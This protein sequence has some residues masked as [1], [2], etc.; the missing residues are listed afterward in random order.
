LPSELLERRPDVRRAE[1]LLVQANANIGVA[2]AQFFPSLSLSD[3][4]G[5][6]SSQ[7][8]KIFESGN[9]YTYAVGSLSQPIFD[10]GKIRANYREA[11][12]KDQELID[13]SATTPV[14]P[15]TS[16]SLP[17]T[18]PFT[19]HSLPYRLPSNKRP[20]LSF[21]CITPLAAAGRTS[22]QK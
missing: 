17:Q 21:S 8:K 14:P 6:S 2:R 4:T 7:L 22:G 16:K 13:T 20:S 11:K 12:A 9:V 3:S 1:E 15:V 5:T 18:P 10:G 19:N